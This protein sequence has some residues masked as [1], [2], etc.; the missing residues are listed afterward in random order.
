[1]V[2][3]GRRRIGK[4][5]LVQEFGKKYKYYQFTGLAPTKN[6][7]IQ[8]QLNEFSR[9]LS[10]QTGLPEVLADDWSK[11]FLFNELLASS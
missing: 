9:Q 4:S 1:M 3:K 10:I 6:T 8:S 2:I 5:R 7:T 11:L